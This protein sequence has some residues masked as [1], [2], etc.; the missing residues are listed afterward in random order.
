MKEESVRHFAESIAPCQSEELIASLGTISSDSEDDV[1]P[2]D[3]APLFP[4]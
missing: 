4:I 1:A 3:L 2:A